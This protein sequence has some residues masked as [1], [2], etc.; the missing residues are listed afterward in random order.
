ML[1][2]LL[3]MLLF[4][5][6]THSACTNMLLFEHS[7]H[8]KSTSRSSTKVISPSLRWKDEITGKGMG[9]EIYSGVDFYKYEL[10]MHAYSM[11]DGCIIH[12]LCEKD[13]N[14]TK[15]GSIIK[16]KI[17]GYIVNVT[18]LF[19]TDKLLYE[20]KFKTYHNSHKGYHFKNYKSCQDKKK[21]IELKNT[22]PIIYY[23]KIIIFYGIII[24]AIY[25]ACPE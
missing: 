21:D 19:F 6:S 1:I 9:K 2:K 20:N 8:V 18:E 5:T 12:R 14:Y 11:D 17:R 10:M 25:Y 24:I 13:S 23:S 7:Q 22:Y 4:I 15:Y 3:L 16:T